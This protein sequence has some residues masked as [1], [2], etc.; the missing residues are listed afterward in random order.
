MRTDVKIGIVVGLIV[1]LVV[2]VYIVVREQPPAEPGRE[3][4]AGS[5]QEPV[6]VNE[7]DYG[8]SDPGG[9]VGVRVVPREPPP[10]PPAEPPAP[11]DS[12]E[13]RVTIEPEE[14]APPAEPPAP[15]EPHEPEPVLTT[16]EPP[17]PPAEPRPEPEVV[18]GDPAPI[19]QEPTASAKTYVVQ[20]GDRGFW[21]IAQKPEIYGDGKYWYLIAKANPD[22]ESSNLRKGQRLVIPPK[23]AA[24]IRRVGPAGGLSVD[25]V[26][27]NKIYV[28]QDGDAGFWGIAQKKEIYGNGKYWQLIAKANPNVDSIN[29][30]AGQ[31]L[32]IP[33]RPASATVPAAVAVGGPPPSLA[34]GQTIYVVEEGDAGFWEIAKKRYGNGA[35][36]QAIAKANPNVNPQRLRAGQKIVIPSIEQARRL[37]S[38][39]STRPVRPPAA[40][41]RGASR[42]FPR[43]I[44]D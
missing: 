42:G 16:Y 20:D 31:K 30:R 41:S 40:P 14:P 5:P 28:V 1:V 34:A 19:I 26:T 3:Q 35:L 43:P 21:G 25:P 38:A 36:W 11:V 8:A 17:A 33:P 27:G 13:V 29:L 37:A 18:V 44:F 9:I 4:A 23:P 2:L 39:P 32:V 24:Q 22:A 6:G 10:A 15:A 12:G 7:P